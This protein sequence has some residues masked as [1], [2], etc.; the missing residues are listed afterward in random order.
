VNQKIAVTFLIAVALT[1]CKSAPQS[2]EKPDFSGT[3][4]DTKP[5]AYYRLTSTKGSSEVGSTTYEFVGG[6][7]NSGPGA[8]L[9][10]KD[11]WIKTTQM[12]GIDK[13]GSI[14]AWVN[15][16]AL[17]KTENHILYVA[18][19]SQSGN[20]FD[21]QFEGD[22]NLRFFTTGGG[23]LEYA[24]DPAT[25]VNQWHMIVATMDAAPGRAIY[26]DGKPVAKD[27]GPNTPKK[28]SQFTIGESPVF[29][30]RFFNGSIADVAIWDR[31]LSP[32]EVAGIYKAS[33]GK[34]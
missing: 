8:Q 34:P 11:A 7:M 33:T 27:Q 15:L 2:S 26:W 24:P 31:A 3:V 23:R 21:L 17:P 19:E 22:N 10:G 29:T 25:L 5:L 4:K 12:G 20:D 6:V 16:A 28:T 32:D 18:G 14:M 13:A 9:N 30:G 1:G